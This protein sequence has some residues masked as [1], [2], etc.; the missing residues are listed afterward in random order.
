MEVD[1][2]LGGL[3]DLL[4]ERIW[5]RRLAISLTH[6]EA[7]ADDL[8]QETLLA[9]VRKSP[10]VV[11]RPRAWLG[12]VA[13]RLWWNR[14]R[15]EARRR[16]H[17]D[18]ATP[19]G[20]VEPTDR[21]VARAELLECLGQ[22]V[23]ALPDPYRVTLLL[24]F[25]EGRTHAEIAKRLD[26]PVETVRTRARR[27]LQLLRDEL[28][29]QHG[30]RRAWQ[31]V[32]LPL[33]PHYLTPAVLGTS[34]ATGGALA[35]S[36]KI[37]ILILAIPLLAICV[38]YGV[39]GLG[40]FQ[41]GEEAEQATQLLETT[42]AEDQPELEGHATHPTP[43]LLRPDLALPPPVDLAAVDRERDLHG[44]VTNASDEP[45]AGA[46]LE[47]RTHPW[48]SNGLWGRKT[49]DVEENLRTTLTAE[50][51]TFRFALTPGEVVELRASKPGL[52]TVL[53]RDCNAGERLDMVMR[54][55]L[56]VT[57]RVRNRQ[58]EP[59]E[60]AQVRLFTTTNVLP[61]INRRGH[62]DAAGRLV[63][64]GV[65]GGGH[66]HVEAYHPRAGPGGWMPNK[67]ESSG[68]QT[69]KI[70]LP[71]GRP[72]R[73]L[74]TDA[75]TGQPIAG[76]RIGSNWTLSFPTT[77]DDRGAYEWPGW[78][79]KGTSVL[80]A[81]ADGYAPLQLR[82]G[83]E[84]VLDFALVPGRT[85]SG[86][87][88][89]PGGAP[90]AGARVAGRSAASSGLPRGSA[91][92]AVRTDADGRFVLTGI[93]T[94]RAFAWTVLSE[95]LAQYVGPNIEPTQWAEG[96]VDVGNIRLTAGRSVDGTAVEGTDTPAAR[97]WVSLSSVVPGRYVR[98]DENMAYRILRTRYTDD[99]GR[100]RFVGLP[101]GTYRLA[102]RP[103]GRQ[104]VGRE[105]V[106]PK[107]RDAPDVTI[108]LPR[109]RE[110][111]VRV[112]TK[113]GR[114][115]EGASISLMGKQAGGLTGGIL[116]GGVTDRNGEFRLLATDEV[117][118]VSISWTRDWG[119]KWVQA[120]NPIHMLK[121]KDKEIVFVVSPVQY[122]TGRV[123]DENDKPISGVYVRLAAEPIMSTTD[124]KGRF[125]LRTPAGEAADL[126][127]NGQGQRATKDGRV[128]SINL[129]I[130]GRSNDVE[131]GSRDVAI[132]ARTVPMTGTLR[133]RVEMP[134]G[135]TP[136]RFLVC[137]SDA[138]GSQEPP[139]PEQPGLRVLTKV[140]VRPVTVCAQVRN[141]AGRFTATQRDV[142]PNGHE[143]TL[144]LELVTE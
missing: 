42:A 4:A 129:P 110:I 55:G 18:G 26:V 23:L 50:D 114:G 112:Q 123:L 46:L 38:G 141:A 61:P 35:M 101:P 76:A 40:W 17:E 87:V 125:E 131:P 97:L 28:D 94:D 51:G 24:R 103:E 68:K 56:T 140:P 89:D 135:S 88:L 130:Y 67:L 77:T 139:D 52:A 12:T 134:D 72:I 57:L 95:P 78:T 73:G 138:S 120:G 8:A 122:T 34:V 9:A 111:L 2:E 81:M 143:I 74:V 85:L 53:R 33:V 105:V 69:I 54:A 132:I 32:L 99:L 144:R 80:T 11:R 27:G 29:S 1:N 62:T 92:V 75:E 10:A 15:G 142:D 127:V 90:I 3:Q 36:T 128:E 98:G 48:R 93:H 14:Q 115:V 5:L 84:T 19:Q 104:E 79:A 116:G 124:A 65:E 7:A 45:V 137:L 118:Q 25:L 30:D 136:E 96:N 106:V 100:F 58:G 59:L 49:R 126:I 6:D 108:A 16:H 63:F 82:V 41:G 44:R 133:V 91:Y 121:E 107:D 31:A 117:Q 70:T 102:A 39:L 43:E 13:R 66:A 22:M 109:A 60:D 64:E 119:R 21:V 37:K 113:E 20:R 71:T 86:R 47:I 83:D